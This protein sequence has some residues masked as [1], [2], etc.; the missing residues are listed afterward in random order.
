MVAVLAEA[1]NER[2]DAVEYIHHLPDLTAEDF[3]GRFGIQRESIRFRRL[4]P[5]PQATLR[6]FPSWRRKRRAWQKSLSGG[7]D[8][9][10]CIVHHVPV[11]SFSTRGVLMVLFPFFEPFNVRATSKLTGSG[12]A[13]IRGALRTFYLRAQWR[14]ALATYPSRTSISE[15]T[16]VWTKRRWRIDSTVIY[17]PSDGSFRPQ[18]KRNLILSVGRFSGF[19]LGTLSK[20]QLEM[21]RAFLELER[22][23]DL[24]DWRYATIG[25]VG[26]R[27]GDHE[28]F[29][30][31]SALTRGARN[32][33]QTV[34]NA[35]RP[36]VKELHESA[37]IFWHAAGFGDDEATNPEL[38]E[39][40]GI[41]TVDAMA[42]GAVPV[43]INKGAQPEIVEHGVSGFLW[44]TIDQLKSYTTALIADDNLRSQMAAAAQTRA[45]TFSREAFVRRF[46]AFAEITK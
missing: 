42:A 17:P 2:G 35:S 16:R 18:Q 27:A 24:V 46:F 41:A 33:I 45:E 29:D 19:Q 6:N 34:A 13:R 8:L 15:Y 28:Y 1:F 10:I 37:K 25:A 11:P 30:E 23:S 43:V 20:R 7:Y 31:V 12:L 5:L 9:F 21:M 44:D 40:F 22:E 14:R 32:S 3:A 26:N 38:M 4:P 36:L 39:H